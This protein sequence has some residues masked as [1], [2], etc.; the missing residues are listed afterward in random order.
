M[1]GNGRRLFSDDIVF[2]H[3]ILNFSPMNLSNSTCRM[4]NFLFCALIYG[5]CFY[6][7]FDWYFRIFDALSDTLV[8]SGEAA[9][10]IYA[11]FVTLA[12]LTTSV[13]S[14]G[15]NRKRIDTLKNRIETVEEFLTKNLSNRPKRGLFKLEYIKCL[16]I[17]LPMIVSLTMEDIVVIHTTTK[18]D[19][20]R[21]VLLDQALIHFFDDLS[22]FIVLTIVF[23]VNQ[24]RFTIF[25]FSIAGSYSSLNDILNS[26]TFA[27]PATSS[28]PLEVEMN[29]LVE[30]N[31]KIVGDVLETHDILCD[32][33][34]N[35][36]SVYRYIVSASIAAIFAGLFTGLT[37][38]EWLLR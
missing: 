12:S 27:F 23:T 37:Y 1:S 18:F 3:N 16:A 9:I 25:A 19:Y 6:G 35:L 22:L 15:L 10:G 32:I 31:A 14:T 2:A 36:L 29:F 8:A 28:F 11:S 26:A 34:E 33:S 21:R 20:Q 30:K 4:P 24:F 13:I 17:L 7:A 5:I 38:L